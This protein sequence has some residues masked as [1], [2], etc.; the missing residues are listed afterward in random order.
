MQRLLLSLQRYDFTAYHVPGKCMYTADVLSRFVNN[1][2]VS[3]VSPL[4]DVLDT[5]TNAIVATITS[6]LSANLIEELRNET[7]VDEQL[8]LLKHYILDGWPVHRNNCQTSTKQYWQFKDELSYIDGLIFRGNCL[9]IPHKLRE[10]YLNRVHYG[11]LGESKCKAR[12]RESIFWP[13][14][15]NDI[16]NVVSSCNVCAKHRSQNIKEPLMP[17][18]EPLL[19]YQRVGLD[20]FTYASKD[21]VII[22]DYYSSFPEIIPVTSTKAATII[23][24][25]KSTFARW[26]KPETLVSDNAPQLICSEFD[27]F[28]TQWEIDHCTSSPYL[29]RSN[30]MSERG[31]QSSKQLIKKCINSSQDFYQSLLIL[32]STPLQCGLSPAQ[33]IMGRRIR[34]NLPLYDNL[35]NTNACNFK[36]NF[37]KEKVKYKHYYDKHCKN[38]PEL[39]IGTYVYIYDTNRKLWDTQAQVM[40]K[41]SARSY[42]VKTIDNV[43]YRRN[44]VH[45]RPKTFYLENDHS[46][47]IDKT[48]VHLRKSKRVTKQ[49]SRLIY[50][51]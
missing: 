37:T 4:E 29:P 21:Y 34:N 15:T 27:D 43:F 47:S 42:L 40:E 14:I 1:E 45:L 33:L 19:P 41:L 28:C 51:N 35:L 38:L 2:K 9:I 16:I 31:V 50:Y 30:G 49:P 32:R 17:Q 5:H 25:L 48:F 36:R 6:S 3:T 10:K 12:A 23:N 18:P 24:V 20:L 7:E 11:H 8:C 26:G 39:S 22:V 13:G 44:R 46:P